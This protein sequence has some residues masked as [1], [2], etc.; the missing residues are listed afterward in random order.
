[1]VMTTVL[2]MES[3]KG[4]TG[5]GSWW[6]ATKDWERSKERLGADWREEGAN[7]SATKTWRS[8]LWGRRGQK[9]RRG[10]WEA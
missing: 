8:G 4:R 10:W 5:G 3:S 7:V 6:L 2:N 9:R 1:M